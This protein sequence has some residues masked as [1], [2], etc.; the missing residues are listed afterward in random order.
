MNFQEIK[1][2]TNTP[3]VVALEPPPGRGQFPVMVRCN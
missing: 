2:R 3:F 1:K